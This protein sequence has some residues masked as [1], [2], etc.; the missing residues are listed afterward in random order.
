MAFETILFEVAG[1]VARLTLN[2]P[3]RLNSFTLQM[4]GEVAEAISRVESMTTRACCSSPAPD[5]ASARDRI[6]PIRR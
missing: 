1:G 3:D 2:R 5:A 4:H 6:S